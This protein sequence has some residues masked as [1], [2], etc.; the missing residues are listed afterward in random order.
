MRV[1]LSWLSEFIDLP[2]KADGLAAALTGLGLKV[3]AI[4]RPGDQIQ[5]VVVG[6]VLAT[7]DHPRADNLIL[8]DVNVGDS[9]R[10]IVCGARNF[11][12]GDRVPVALPGA[13][14]PDVG[15]IASKTLKGEMSDGML[16][17]P[18]ELG[19]SEDHS[20]ILVLSS[21]AELGSDVREALGLN[22]VVFEFEIKPN[23]PDAMS[24]IGIARDLAAFF[25]KELRIP[26]V[27][28]VSSGP[29]ITTATDVSVE[30]VVG[31]PRYLARVIKGVRIV[32]APWPVQNRLSLAGFR[33][34]SNVV[35]AT[36]YALLVFGHPLH[37]FDLKLLEGNRIVVRR[38]RAGERIVTLD[39]EDRKLEPEDLVI[40]DATRAVA[41]AG[42]MG[43]IGSEV[44]DATSDILLESAYFDPVSILRTS[45]RHGLRS[46]ASARFERG[47][48]PNG[49]ATAADYASRL[50]VEWAGGQV[51]SGTIDRYDS[52][53]TPIEVSLRPKRASVVLG[54][55]F[56]AGRIATLLSRL[57][58][59]STV[60][61]GVVRSVVP[62]RRPDIT[63]EADLIEEVARLVGYD[64][65]PAGLPS[66][67]NRAGSLTK[68]QALLR[69]VRTL[70]AGA[71]VWEGQTTSLV[72]P[73][74]IQRSGYEGASQPLALVNSL[75]VEESLLRPSLL[76]G[77]LA[78]VSRNVA[79]RNLTVKIFE[80]GHCFGPS[81]D[82]LPLEELRLGIVLH[83]GL[84]GEWHSPARDMDF[85]D[86]K[87]IVDA[88]FDGL[89]LVPATYEP[90]VA[91]PFHRTRAARVSVEGNLLG[92]IGELS[93]EVSARNDLPHRA[94]AGE[95]DLAS[96]L[97]LSRPPEIRESAR[98]PAG[99]V[100]LAV[101]VPESTPAGAVLATAR[102]AG[103]EFLEEAR[104][105]DLYVG[106][107]IAEGNKSIA[108][109]LKFRHP[110]RTLTDAEVHSW[111]DAI[112][113]AITSA[114]GGRV[115]A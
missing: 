57:G 22:D 66:G 80:I 104:I 77:L 23:R 40:A 14:L 99:L 19:V 6:E 75:S 115:R 102:A 53:R 68:E 9:K 74:D 76:P 103:G 48:D 108:M 100:D 36:N 83:G 113:Q 63:I 21:P 54:K 37:A 72:G 93:Y 88:L 34:I 13:R 24:I 30:D 85:F 110:D 87:G 89:R 17:S 101:E 59:E 97:E 26:E 106:E 67:R 91:T 94:V 20:G 92:V 82:L 78:A 81:D 84:D 62:T 4:H 73:A 32:P 35:D 69:K 31:C 111:R 3:E 12:I 56:S 112:A 51:A 114:H 44:S 95:L 109:S 41:I 64:S 58:L 96:I 90:V 28:V 45:R 61:D 52:P 79:R 65:F 18:R 11:A 50:V 10:R 39:E 25:R 16:C 7:V 15:A 55:R 42:V 71:G 27:S 86:L 29:E 43:G 5:G 107:Q 98:F 46:E 49:V 2:R 38:A 105:F 47:A 60:H 33:P 70:L 1:P 8:V